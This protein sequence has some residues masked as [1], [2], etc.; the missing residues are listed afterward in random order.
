MTFNGP[1]LDLGCG[2]GVFAQVLFAS[3][4]DTGIDPNSRELARARQ[5]RMYSELLQSPGHAIPK[6]DGYYRTIFSNSVLEHIPDLAP[7]FREIYRLLAV[8]GRFYMTVP[9]PNFEHYTVLSQLLTALG[10]SGLAGRYREFCSKVLWRQSHYYTVAGWEKLV[11]DF[12]FK[13]IDSFSYD[14][15]RV[16]LLNDCLYPFSLAEVINKKL[17]NRWTLLPWLRRIF[18][19]PLSIFAQHVLKDA[20]KAEDGG[21]VF[22]ALTK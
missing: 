2:D 17:F 21:L 16:C 9:A 19:F 7:V 12:G 1:I 20:E 14:P 15:K 6:P 22:L 13:V 11:S 8:D 5:S 18:L 10:F 3:P 4:I